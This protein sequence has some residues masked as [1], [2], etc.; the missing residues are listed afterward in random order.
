MFVTDILTNGSYIYYNDSAHEVLDNCFGADLKQG[1]YL[2][3]IVSRKKQ[4]I[5]VIMDSFEK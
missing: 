5:P 3:G 2:E 4:V 1:K